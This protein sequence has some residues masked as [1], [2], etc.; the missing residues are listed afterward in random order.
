M[1]PNA[2]FERDLEQWLQTEAPASAPAGFHASVMDRART[3]R[4]RPGW[5]RTFP[6]RR[7]GR[8]RGM[9]L[10]AA[11]AL[12][13]VGGAWAA[14]SGILRLPTVVP[15]VP[16]PSVIAVAT[17]SP[18]ATF[19][20]PTPSVRPSLGP[21]P[22]G[23]AGPLAWTEASLKEDWPA[24]VRPEPA[25]GAS[26]QPMPLT[27]FDPTGDTGSDIDPWVD[28][29]AVTG[30]TSTVHLKL[31]SNHPPVV[32]PAEQWIAYG[33][34]IDDDRDGV[35]DWRYGI[36]NTPPDAEGE[37][38][39]G[40]S[41]DAK[42]APAVFGGT[43]VWRTNLHTGRTDH[44]GFLGEAWRGVWPNGSDAN[45]KFGGTSDTAGK[46]TS[47]WGIALDMPFYTWAS[48]IVNGRVVA[49]DSAPDAGWFI[50]TPGAKPGGTY[51]LEDP[52]PLHLSMT[53]PDGWTD[54]GGPELTRDGGHTN[55]QFLVLDNPEDPCPDDRTPL[56]PSFDD[57]VS[58]LE[59]MPNIDFSV[60]R[61]GTVDGYRAVYLEER[62]VDGE[63]D[64]M[65][66]SP[67]SLEIHMDRRCRWRSPGD[68]GQRGF[69][70]RR[71]CQVRGPA[72]RRVDQDRRSVAVVFAASLPEPDPEADP[73]A[74][75]APARGRSRSAERSELDRHGR[76]QELRARDAVRGRG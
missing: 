52:F 65:G 5:T 24:P 19:P 41:R 7:F 39:T 33:V 37:P 36:D 23:P 35:P 29:R 17:A 49:T 67:I 31:V 30:D 13:L 4:Q 46:G 70:A 9:T 45:F 76:Q 74:D 69:G 59:A 20:S 6:A 43:R 62:P 11:A 34:V 57:L 8:G 72:D 56:G 42:G 47:T 21:P 53:V 1:N 66:S 71:A 58:Y 44:R 54:H 73:E 26:V 60:M 48:V 3:L 32:D 28:I 38:M 15:P 10:L 25:G 51:L 40:D 55:L 61:Y 63:F 27:Y 2:Q 14:G 68:R 75:A 64:C 12:L 18:D 50:A 22:S 16:E